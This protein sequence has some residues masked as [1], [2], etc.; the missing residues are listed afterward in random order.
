MSVTVIVSLKVAEFSKWKA[1]FDAHAEDRAEAGLNAV[2]HQNIDD[3]N[4]A[5]VIVTA[6]SKEAFLAFFTRPETQEMQKKAGVL[7]PPEIK[8]IN[9]A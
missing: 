4:N 3:P 9:P 5:I 7:G 1:G 8:F 2:A 6:P